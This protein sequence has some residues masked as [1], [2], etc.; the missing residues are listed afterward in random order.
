M[1][2][3]KNHITGMKQGLYKNVVQCA[4][5]Y[6]EN[7]FTNNTIEMGRKLLENIAGNR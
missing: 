7:T 2:C 3:R 6:E 4:Q 5:M 1:E